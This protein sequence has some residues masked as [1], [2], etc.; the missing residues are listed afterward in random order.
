LLAATAEEE[1]SGHEGI[2]LLLLN[3][4]LKTILQDREISCA[5][6]GEPTNMDLAVAEKGLMVLDCMA[7]GKAGHAARDEGENAIYN[8]LQDIEWFRNYQFDKISE[9]LGSV[10]MS[11]TVINTENKAHNMIPSQCNFVV[12]VRVTEMYTH[13]EIY[14]TVRQ[15]VN[16][17]VAPR[18]M[19]LRSSS[20]A[21]DHPLVKAGIALGKKC[22]GSPTSSDKALMHFPALKCGPGES[23]RSHTADEYIYLHEIEEGIKGYIGLLSQMVL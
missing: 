17:S 23:G 11:V 19:R 5:I 9:W 15:H 6:V 21:L 7:S 22:Y 10:K 13:E 4:K 2:E 1:I 16:C 12:D 8:V 18:S 14:E 3:K 20:I